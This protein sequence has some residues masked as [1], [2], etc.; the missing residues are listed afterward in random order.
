MLT[1]APLL[2]RVLIEGLKMYKSTDT[3][4]IGCIPHK[5]SKGILLPTFA[6]EKD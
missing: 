6:V 5:R 1:P 4:L 2:L 3:V